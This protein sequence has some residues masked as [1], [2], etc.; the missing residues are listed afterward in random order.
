MRITRLGLVHRAETAI[1][2]RITPAPLI[3]YR[4]SY[5]TLILAR[6]MMRCWT[7]EFRDGWHS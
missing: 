7:E 1:A 3:S 6:E 4:E 2:R 5:D